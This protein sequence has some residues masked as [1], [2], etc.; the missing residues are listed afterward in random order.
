[1]KLKRLLSI[2]LSVVLVLSAVSSLTFAEEGEAVYGKESIEFVKALGIAEI[3]EEQLSEKITRAELLKMLSIASGYGEMKSEEVLFADL[4]LD[5]AYEP[6]IKAL[7]KVGVISAD[8]NGNIYPDSE[9]SLIEAVSVAVKLAGY[10]VMAEAKGGYPN[11][12]YNVAKSKEF[13]K[14]LPSVQYT[15]MTK[16]MALKLIENTLKADLMIQ[17]D[18]GN[19]VTFAEAEGRNF[20]WEVFK[21]KHIEGIVN[22]VDISRIAGENDV[23]GFFIEVDGLELEARDVEGVRAYLGYRVNAYYTDERGYI[24][25]LKWIEKSDKNTETLIDI[26]DVHSISGQKIKVYADNNKYKTYSFKKSIPVLYNGVS[27]VKPF[28]MALIAGKKGTIKLLD[29]TGDNTADIAVLDVY[30]TFIVAH[31]DSVNSV[32]YDKYNSAK[33][34]KLDTTLDEPFV[35]IYNAE[36]KEVKIGDIKAGNVLC[37][38]ESNSDAYQKLIRAYIVSN[39]VVGKIGKTK[40]NGNIVVIDDVEYDVDKT[41]KTK[42]SNLLKSGQSVRL[43]MDYMGNVVFVEKYEGDITEYGYLIGADAGSGGLV[44]S[45]KLKFYSLTDGIIVVDAA[46][47]IV[48]DG[49]SYKTTASDEVEKALTKL[50]SASKTMFPG[51]DDSCYAQVMKY[52]L[53]ENGEMSV[54]DTILNVDGVEPDRY[55]E[56]K[57]LNDNLLSAKAETSERFDDTPYAYGPRIA[58]KRTTPC[59]LYPSPLE[60]HNLD[61]P[62]LYIYS[63]VDAV[64]RDYVSGLTVRGFYDDGKT[65]FAS[66]LGCVNTDTIAYMYNAD[67]LGIV[68]EYTQVYDKVTDEVKNC[69]IVVGKEGEGTYTID[70]MMAIKGNANT[71]VGDTLYPEDLKAGDVIRYFADING[72]IRLLNFHFRLGENAEAIEINKLGTGKFTD[73]AAIRNGLVY[74]SFDGGFIVY[75]PTSDEA[76]LFKTRD[77]SGVTL[78]KCEYVISKGEVYFKYEPNERYNT[79]ETKTAS[80]NDIKSYRNTG[81]N[82]SRI[83]VQTNVGKPLAVVIY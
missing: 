18:F 75:F 16:G 3:T 36:G 35:I 50:N 67:S 62:D 47:K 68:K 9:I 76:D 21:I 53:N 33:S 73:G 45:L 34:I 11:G 23:P 15:A 24:P 61:D 71:E 39:N 29:N 60:N 6:Y 44:G 49:A 40:D 80:S 25:V 17:T 13:L 26:S 37:I 74:D 12:Y 14:N 22:G 41:C 2:I 81:T 30:D 1:M 31:V 56:N 58:L 28:S 77:L 51:V 65:Y 38:F 8:A 7:A 48:I 20:L 42:Y 63:T 66:L 19:D 27:T 78:D 5:N 10:G 57:L 83:L 69:L 46:S 43:H 70:P 79:M 64:M 32:V 72:Y 4:A 54:I 82:C 55:D 59:F 52:S